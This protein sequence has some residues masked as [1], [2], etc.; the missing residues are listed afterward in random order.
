MRVGEKAEPAERIRLLVHAQNVGGYRLAAHA[1]ETVATRAEVAFDDL[2]AAARSKAELRPRRVG[3]FDRDVL[4]FAND[5]AARGFARFEQVAR[6]LGLSVDRD[7]AA[8]VLRK[9]DPEPLPGERDLDA[10]VNEPLA[11]HPRVD[12]GS[13]NDV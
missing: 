11:I 2:L 9:I 13:P 10:F 12:A 7:A 8:R 1:V 4:G 6:Q 5:R 3:A